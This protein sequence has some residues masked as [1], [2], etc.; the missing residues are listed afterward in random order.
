[1]ASATCVVLTWLATRRAGS[2]CTVIS[3]T[4][5]PST[6]TSPTSGSP[7]SLGRTVNSA[8]SRSTSGS[9]PVISYCSIGKTDGVRRSALELETAREGRTGC[10]EASLDLTE[11]ELHVRVGAEVETQFGRPAHREGADPAKTED[12]AQRLFQRPRHGNRH[13]FGFEGAAA[14]QHHD[15]G[16]GHFGID[17]GGQREQRPQS[18]ESK[19]GHREVD[20]GPVSQEESGDPH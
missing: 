19:K 6:D 1:M 4:R 17:A 10:G 13:L 18:T 14:G 16:K 5:P 2:S 7:A 12:P 20:G 3:R 15:P 11:R 9:A 8:R